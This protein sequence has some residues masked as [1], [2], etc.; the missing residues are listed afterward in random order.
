MF[1]VDSSITYFLKPKKKAFISNQYFNRD[2]MLFS[3]MSQHF[4]QLSLS[5]DY[6]CTAARHDELF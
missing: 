4:S 5:S 2:N 3:K 1:R 6:L